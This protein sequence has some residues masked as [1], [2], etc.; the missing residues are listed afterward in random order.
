MHQECIASVLVSRLFMF[1]H[2]IEGH[3]P[4]FGDDGL[5]SGRHLIDQVLDGKHLEMDVHLAG[6][7]LGQVKDV[8]D[9]V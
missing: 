1:I 3:H 8:V 9:E 4:I 5:D 6:F 2:A 7:D